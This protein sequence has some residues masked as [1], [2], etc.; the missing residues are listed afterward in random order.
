M[1]ELPDKVNEAFDRI[2][3]MPKEEQDAIAKRAYQ[4]LLETDP[5]ELARVGYCIRGGRVVKIVEE[6]E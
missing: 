5:A 2:R 6:E 3:A 1:S 4:K